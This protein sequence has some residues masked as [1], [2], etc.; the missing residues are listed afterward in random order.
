MEL[1][2]RMQ[3]KLMLPIKLEFMTATLKFFVGQ[4]I[5]SKTAALQESKIQD[6]DSKNVSCQMS[7]V[8]SIYYC[9]IGD[10]LG[11]G[12]EYERRDGVT[13]FIYSQA[14]LIYGD[15]MTKEDVFY[16]VL[17]IRRLINISAFQ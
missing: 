1:P 7:P 16:Y 10:L 9:D 11:G 14:R 17:L 8:S 2:K 6:T 5:E 15:A 3:R 12:E 4:V 13:D